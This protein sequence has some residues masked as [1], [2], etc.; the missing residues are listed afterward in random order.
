M[1]HACSADTNTRQ[2]EVFCFYRHRHSAST[3]LYTNTKDAKG[4]ASPA[5]HLWPRAKVRAQGEAA[6]LYVCATLTGVCH[7][8]TESE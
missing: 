2:A 7:T 8:V 4:Y 1:S 3:H 6:H 5:T